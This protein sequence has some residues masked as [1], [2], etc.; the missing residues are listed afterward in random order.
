MPRGSHFQ[1][2]VSIYR[3]A[4]EV[5]LTVIIL[6]NLNRFSNYFTERFLGKFAVKSLLK[7]PPQPV[8]VARLRRETVM[9]ENK[10]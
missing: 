2:C 1:A 7:I 6:L 8:Y 3:V 4:K 5:K 10:R 9:P